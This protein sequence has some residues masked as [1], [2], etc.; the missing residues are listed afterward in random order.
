MIKRHM[1]ALVAAVA[2]GVVAIG[3][4]VFVAAAPAAD[5]SVAKSRSLSAN[6]IVCDGTI[7]VTVTLDGTPGSI[8]TKTDILLVMDQ[9]GSVSST[10]MT[11]ARGV[12]KSI[13]GGIDLTRN[14]VGLVVFAKDARVIST[15]A[16]ATDGGASLT[17]SIDAI[18]YTPPGTDATN[19]ADA[20]LD[21]QAAF[22]GS[23][24]RAIVMI[25]DG[26][27]TRGNVNNVND[28]TEANNAAK[29]ARDAGTTI[30]TVR[31]GGSSTTIDNRLKGWAGSPSRFFPASPSP[32]GTI[33]TAIGPEKETPAATTA[34]VVDTLGPD[35]DLV[36]TSAGTYDPG[37]RTLT[38]NAGTLDDAPQ[39]L[40][41]R[42]KHNKSVLGVAAKHVS[43][44]VTYTSDQE[45]AGVPLDNPS[46]F[47]RPCGD[48]LAPAQTCTAG[49]SCVLDPELGEATQQETG[50][51]D[52]A[53]DAGS[54]NTTL[55]LTK[56]A[57]V[58]AGVCGGN[59]TNSFVQA[60][61]LPLTD[62]LVVTLYIPAPQSGPLFGLT[63]ICLGTN[64]KFRTLGFG[65]AQQ[66]SDGLWYGLLPYGPTLTYLNGKWVRSPSINLVES[67]NLITIRGVSTRV[68]KVVFEVHSVTGSNGQPIIGSDGRPGYDPKWGIGG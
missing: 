45:L 60:D 47:V 35:F 13:V 25:T 11:T 48:I 61:V 15:P 9:S 67:D 42:V 33:V 22:S 31:L 27:T 2:V 53:L 29:A 26:K 14:K 65:M 49:S 18:P 59:F 7:D 44:S 51:A 38:W 34:K 5:G 50:I 8:G 21:A 56:L 43:Q 57:G 17:A 32:A 12:A 63:K 37:T 6:D 68:T 66:A 24:P 39:T 62:K 46:V 58:P 52:L 4:G 16:N 64:L 3:T 40:T 1:R 23:A 28:V 10:L 55:F 20:F 54:G 30:F 36:I 19:H 41:Y